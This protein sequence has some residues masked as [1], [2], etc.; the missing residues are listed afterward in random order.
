MGGYQ[1]GP[2]R[3]RDDRTWGTSLAWISSGLN[4]SNFF[5]YFYFG[6]F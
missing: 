1:R 2:S 4:P 5:L 3:V 6:L